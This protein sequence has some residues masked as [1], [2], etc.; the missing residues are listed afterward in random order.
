M[1]SDVRVSTDV[2]GSSASTPAYRA[3]QRVVSCGPSRSS[4]TSRVGPTPRITSETGSWR[5]RSSQMSGARVSHALEVRNESRRRGMRMDSTSSGRRT[6]FRPGCI[7]DLVRV[8]LPSVVLVL[9]HV[10]PALGVVD[11]EH[12]AVEGVTV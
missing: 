2:P 11:G 5:A 10:E 12:H 3:G 6:A 4:A 1:P 8:Q 7:R 9:H